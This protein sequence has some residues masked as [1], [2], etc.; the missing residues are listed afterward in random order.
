M[1]MEVEE[2]PAGAPESHWTANWY[3]CMAYAAE[4]MLTLVLVPQAQASK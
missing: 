3:S 2:K 4:M 1:E